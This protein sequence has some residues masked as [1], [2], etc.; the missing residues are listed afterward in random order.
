MEINKALSDFDPRAVSALGGDP[1]FNSRR[2]QII[3]HAARMRIPAM[4]EWREF[5][6][7]GGLMS[8]GTDLPDVYRQVGVYS[9]RVIKYIAWICAHV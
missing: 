1:F 4:Y 5:V 6:A 3:A 9:S 8:Y 7:A 2:N